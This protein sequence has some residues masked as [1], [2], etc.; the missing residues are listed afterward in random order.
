MKKKSILLTCIVA[1]MALAMFVGCDNAPVLPSF[2]VSGNITQTGDFLSGQAF[3]P[4]KFSVTVTY[5]NG[6]IV[7][8]D[9]TVSV[10]LA[11]AS[12]TTA[13]AGEQV[14][15]YLGKNYES[16]DV[17]A[18]A[19]IRAYDISSIAVEGPSSFVGKATP[20]N[21]DLKVTATYLDNTGAEK[22]MVLRST[23]FNVV[24]V[25]YSNN[26]IG[27]NAAQESVTGYVTV[28]PTVGQVAADDSD[29]AT[30][31]ETFEFTATYEPEELPGE[32]AEIT[33][34]SFKDG[35]VLPAFKYEKMP[36][37]SFENFDIFV[38]YVGSNN[39]YKLEVDPGL[40][41]TYL[42]MNYEAL[43]STD[44]T[45]TEKNYRAQVTYGDIVATTT[46]NTTTQK[47]GYIAPKTVTLA[48]AVADSFAEMVEKTALPELS[49]D[50]FI[51]GA[52]C[53]NTVVP[54]DADKVELS[55]STKDHT[56]AIAE[57]SEGKVP[58]V[59]TLDLY[60]IAEYQGV[61]TS[62]KVND[63]I[64]K[65][66]TTKYEGNGLTVSLGASYEQPFVQYYDDIN[67]VINALS[68]DDLTIKLEDG[69]KPVTIVPA[70]LEVYYSTSAPTVDGD[71]LD[72]TLLTDKAYDSAYG[73]SALMTPGSGL[74]VVAEYTVVD[75]DG[76]TT[77]YYGYTS[78]SG[79]KATATTYELALG[80]GEGITTPV[81]GT[82]VSSYTL[83]AKNAAGI[84]SIT[85]LAKDHDGYVL[86]V[87]GVAI[88]GDRWTTDIA[89]T[90][91]EQTVVVYTTSSPM[92]SMETT[93][94]AGVDYVEASSIKV[95]M[96]ET[97]KAKVLRIGDVPSYTANDFKASATTKSGKTISLV[98]DSV[99]YP[100]T[101]KVTKIDTGFTVYVKHVDST[102]KE[103]KSP[104]DITVKAIEYVSPAQGGFTL[105]Y[106]DEQYGNNAQILAKEYVKGDFTI[107]AA[108][109]NKFADTA[110]DNELYKI[111]AVKGSRGGN[112]FDWPSGNEFVAGD[113]LTFTISYVDG[114]T[115]TKD[116]PETEWKTATITLNFVSEIT[117]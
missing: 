8:A 86:V 90:A 14:I 15:A 95:E 27:P 46:N 34:I 104:V 11:D 52:Y 113:T 109:V 101:L 13:N 17:F 42:G 102:G 22:T 56:N 93:I 117:E 59:N 115:V 48:I 69:G 76:N 25:E 98:V 100:P 51:I 2:V 70:N 63:F 53:N 97:G 67:D 112:E 116:D 23:E 91:A 31:K 40:E 77:I 62:V 106:D 29:K 87:N 57:P 66:P 36:V 68:A 9:E 108:S 5:D 33:R 94:P 30:V 107:T 79:K 73:N 96:T 6:R 7:A 39:V 103:T 64:T 88:G 71:K 44:F 16:Q 35:A 80:Y 105:T 43:T 58:G 21:S 26:D 20:S 37:P 81:V 45:D 83:T 47:G 38:K 24:D 55:F 111:T 92:V 18:K 110:N 65:A 78:V 19:A 41:F 32:I 54:V 10:M 1:I 3:D 114:T 84:V 28:I 50:D 12:D 4:S 82:L 99:E 49:A 85:D 74:Y 60:V 61:K 72:V 89:V 75:E